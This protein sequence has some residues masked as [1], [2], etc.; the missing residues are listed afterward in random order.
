MEPTRRGRKFTLLYN[1][2]RATLRR[3]A[4]H[5][6]GRNSASALTPLSSDYSDYSQKWQGKRKIFPRHTQQARKHTRGHAKH[7]PAVWWS[8][9]FSYPPFSSPY[10]LRLSVSRPHRSHP[11][12]ALQTAPVC[13]TSHLRLSLTNDPLA[14]VPLTLP[15]R[16]QSG[17]HSQLTWH[18]AVATEASTH[19]V[20]YDSGG[21]YRFLLEVEEP[22]AEPLV[23]A[24]APLPCA[25]A[26]ALEPNRL[27]LH[28]TEGTHV[29]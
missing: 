27:W 12:R 23:P 17:L 15:T 28:T 7:E 19:D 13:H 9:C 21:V 11:H 5:S 16:R 24:G 20:G 18:T 14:S 25:G 6:T 1:Y 3:A 2:N 8:P 10:N 29:S 26:G 4:T 22:R